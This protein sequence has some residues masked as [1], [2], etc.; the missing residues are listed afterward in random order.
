FWEAMASAALKPTLEKIT[1]DF[2]SSQQYVTVDLQVYPDYTTLETKTLA[3][4]AA[5]QTPTMAQCYESWAA[6][7][8]QSNALAD[9]QPYIGAKDGISQKS[10]DDI[11]PNLLQDGKLKGREYMFPFNKSTYILYY[12]PSLLQ[13]AGISSPPATWAQLFSDARKVTGGGHWGLDAGTEMES[14]FESQI[15]DYGGAMTNQA[16]TRATFDS[17]AGQQALSAWVDGIKNGSIHNIGSSQYDD[18]DFGAQ[19]IA[20]SVDTSAGYSYKKEDAGTA[21]QLKTAPW[22]AGPHGAHPPILGTNA[23]IFSSATK[24]EQQGAFQFIK[25]FTST[26]QTAVWSK[27]TNYLPVRKSAASAMA[28][29]YA[30]NPN[31]KVPQEQL[32]K[33]VFEPSNPGWDQAQTQITT[34]IFNALTGQTSVQQALSTAQA[35]ATTDL[36]QASG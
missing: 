22:P 4:L 17:K 27:G 21:F 26:E 16:E 29:F 23:C 1:D 5:H 35:Q 18:S 20:F 28:S 36:Q 10:L 2:N 25:Y 8:Q 12:N 32:P 3:A 13:A 11:Y 31:Q 34:Q 33:G 7:Y 15:Q 30:Q 6:K 14:V 24:A 9:M 19:K